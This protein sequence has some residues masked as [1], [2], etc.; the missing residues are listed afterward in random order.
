MIKPDAMA[1]RYFERHRNPDGRA[2]SEKKKIERTTSCMILNALREILEN[3]PN[4]T[5][6]RV[7]PRFGEI[8]RMP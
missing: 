6:K 5:G 3:N 1:A 4:A 8:Y 2:L 7:K